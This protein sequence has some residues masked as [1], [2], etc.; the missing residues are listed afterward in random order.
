MKRTEEESEDTKTHFE[1]NF[2]QR[3]KDGELPSS[4]SDYD[5]PGKDPEEYKDKNEVEMGWK[6]PK[7]GEV[8]KIRLYG[9]EKCRKCNENI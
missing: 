9:K 6:C 3:I 5:I 8:T 7:C 2:G 4:S 1:K